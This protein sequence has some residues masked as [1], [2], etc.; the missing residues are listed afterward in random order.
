[1]T[2][3]QALLARSAQGDAAAVRAC[4]ARFGPLVWSLAR[5]LSPTSADA[6]DAAQEI[7]V[8]LWAHGGRYDPSRASEETFVAMVA[9]RRLID[10][11]RRAGRRPEIAPLALVEDAA[12]SGAPAVEVAAEASLAARAMSGLRPEQRE[13]LR[14][15]L[16]EG[17]T[18]DEIA[19]RTGMPLGTVKAHARRGLQRIRGLLLGEDQV[20]E[21]TE[22]GLP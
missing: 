21:P 15:S 19:E 12:G 11:H 2:E 3:I 6:E 22:G 1:M 18:H 13:V 4:I 8:D 5:R 20:D 14:L 10:R 9:R 16:A 7:F 17:L